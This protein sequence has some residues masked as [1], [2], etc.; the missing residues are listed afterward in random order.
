MAKREA[1]FTKAVIAAEPIPESGRVAL[2]DSGESGLVLWT[3][4]AGKKLFQLY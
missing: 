2:Y 4:S 3:T 1:H